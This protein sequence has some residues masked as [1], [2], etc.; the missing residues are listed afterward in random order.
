MGPISKLCSESGIP[1]VSLKWPAGLLTNFEMINR[2]VKKLEE[3][4]ENR[5]AGEWKKLVKHE[6]VKLQKELTKLEKFYRGILPMKK[7][8]DAIFVI[9]VKKEKNA[10]IEARAMKIPIV[11]VVDTN[12]DPALVDHP[13]PGNDDSLGSIEYFA[14]EIIGSYVRH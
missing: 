2:N 4:R 8:P 7:I 11:A 3:M 5:D 14:K 13:I 9:D 10:V 1:Y 12:V 6:Q